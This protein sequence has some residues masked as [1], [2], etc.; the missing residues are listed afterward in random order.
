ML[1]NIKTIVLLFSAAVFTMGCVNLKAVNGF[2]VS[3]EKSFAAENVPSYGYT[4]YCYDSSYIFKSG[5]FLKNYDCDSTQAILYDSIIAKEYSLLST[6]FGAL[7]KLSGSTETIR[8]DTLASALGP[9]TYGSFTVTAA[10]SGAATAIGTAAKYL[11]TV[12]VVGKD[13]KKNLI[14]DWPAIK[15]N[16]DT[17]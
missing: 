11:L 6:W 17:L 7:A 13:I 10:E 16:L 4:A 3:G 5:R 8:V 2:A 15:M 12:S 14:S 1:E 9:G